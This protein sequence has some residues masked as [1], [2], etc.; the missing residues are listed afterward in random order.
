MAMS[1]NTRIEL[2]PYGIDVTIFQKT[3]AVE[4]KMEKPIVFCPCALVS[5]K[6]VDLAIRAMALKSSGSL[7][8]S[9]SGPLKNDLTILGT[10]LLGKRFKII[11]LDYSQIAGYYQASDLVTLPSLNQEN[12]PMVFL[13]SLA[14][15]KL[16]VTTDNPRS[17]WMLENAG[18]Y[19]NPRD[20]EAYAKALDKAV[21]QTKTTTALNTRHALKKFKMAIIVDKYQ[22]LFEEITRN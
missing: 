22:R 3:K 20:V 15:G 7:L 11:S 19:C 13:E 8:V 18:I 12:S 9:G 21:M 5:Y 4:L 6:Q 1:A 2:I 14:S 10:R 16:V 17:R